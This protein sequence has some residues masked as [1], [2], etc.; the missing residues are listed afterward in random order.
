LKKKLDK[1]HNT[2]EECAYYDLF[3]VR[4]TVYHLIENPL[5]KQDMLDKLTKSNIKFPLSYEKY[6][7]LV[8]RDRVLRVRKIM[9][10]W[11]D[12]TK[13]KHCIQ[14]SETLLYRTKFSQNFE[15]ILKN[16]A[17]AEFEKKPS[18]IPIKNCE[19]ANLLY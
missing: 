10:T 19:C 7:K 4:D 14:N 15:F 18:I 6:S 9:E 13:F 5:L 17:P 8:V 11:S 12:Q 2:V 16:E 3:Q 1:Y